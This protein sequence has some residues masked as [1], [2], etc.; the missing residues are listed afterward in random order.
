MLVPES[1][2]H[3]SDW[4]AVSL[5]YM[6]RRV[7]GSPVQW[8]GLENASV[9]VEYVPLFIKMKASNPLKRVDV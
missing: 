4:A 5:K 1:D 7:A 2:I 8:Y 6:I 9:I 3:P